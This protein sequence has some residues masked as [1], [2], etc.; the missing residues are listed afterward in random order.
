[1][2]FLASLLYLLYPL[3]LPTG[4]TAGLGPTWAQEAMDP[5]LYRRPTTISMSRDGTVGLVVG[6]SEEHAFDRVYVFHDGASE[7]IPMP[8]KSLLARFFLSVYNEERGTTGFN[9]ALLTQIRNL[10]VGAD[11][12]LYVGVS[13]SFDGAYLGEQ[14]ASFR[15]SSSTWLPSPSVA[16]GE[17]VPKNLWVAAADNSGDVGYVGDRLY[18]DPASQANL[19]P[20]ALDDVATWVHAGHFT[21]LGNGIVT[22]VCGNRVVG[23]DAHYVPS[24]IDVR[25]TSNAVL[26]EEWNGGRHSVL[27]HGLAWSVNA[28]GDAVGD[29]RATLKSVGYPT[30]WHKGKTI[31]LSSIHGSA[32]AIADDGTIVGDEESRAFIIRAGDLQRR[33]ILLDSWLVGSGW[34]VRAAYAISA[35]GDILAVA[36][37]GG[38]D[39]VVLLV[40]K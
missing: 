35:N 18:L 12:T 38:L 24:G 29:D 20:D 3:A 19:S 10:V 25:P 30:L 17:S 28:D 27:G 1:M 15:W 21:P 23:Y 33:P 5:V 11:D 39:H 40:P 16:I 13:S 36:S 14:E 2:T 26:A 9:E 4:T 34:H 32:F 6:E 37:R 7:A 8:P 22:A 31:R